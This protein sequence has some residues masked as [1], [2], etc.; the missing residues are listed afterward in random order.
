MQNWQNSK[1][2]VYW[3]ALTIFALPTYLIRFKVILPT[4]LLELNIYLMFISFIWF[5]RK[6]LREL[7]IDVIMKLGGMLWPII[8]LTMTAIISLF[9]TSEL[10]AAL[11]LFKAYFIDGLLFLIIVI[12]V[13]KEKSDYKIIIR[14]MGLSV[15]V[16]SLVGLLQY[17]GLLDSPAPWIGQNPKRISSVFEFPNAVGLYLGPLITLLGGILL[18]DD[19]LAKWERWAIL[20]VFVVGLLAILMAFSKGAFIGV[21]LAMLIGGIFSGYRKIVLGI[22]I[23][24]VVLA[25]SSPL[26]RH[27]TSDLIGRNDASSDERI[28]I[29][30]GTERLLEDHWVWGAGLGG[31]PAMYKNYKIPNHITEHLYPH[32]IVLDFWVE[33]GVFGVVALGWYLFAF[34]KMCVS[35][36]RQGNKGIYYALACATVLSMVS[37]ILHGMIDNPFFKNDL[38]LIWWLLAGVIASLTVKDKSQVE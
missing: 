34:F 7:F 6:N 25:V 26:I 8:F 37:I 10:N 30:E 21:V 1:I 16:I 11:G 9:V 32:N 33:F 19:K 15:L 3:L 24:L 4:N 23:L 14:A 27:K 20:L 28:V 31:F 29:W 12:G 36:L 17:I 22:F 38:A 5:N 35:V 2:F 18:F 13:L